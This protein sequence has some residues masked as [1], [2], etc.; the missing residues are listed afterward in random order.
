LNALPLKNLVVADFSRVLAG[1]LATMVLADLGADV[2]KVESP[3]T[4]DETRS[5]GPP[6][7][8]DGTSTYYLAVNRNK[9][10]IVLDLKSEADAS[11]ALR[12]AEMA[13]VVIENFRPGTMERFG[14]GYE[15]LAAVNPGV[16]F[17]SITGFGR[18]GGADLPGYDLL[19]QALGGLM[20]ITGA[21]DGPPTKVGVALVDVLAGLFAVSG[22]L[23]ALIERAASGEG[24]RVDVSLMSSIL[25]GLVNQASAHVVAGQTPGRIGNRHPS[26][27]PYETFT[28]MDGDLVI[29]VG[30]DQQFRRLVAALDL[31]ELA[32]DERFATNG[33]RVDNAQAL[34]QNIEPTLRMRA[35]AE[36]TA[37]LAASRIPCGPVNDIAEA[38]DLAERLGLDPV[39]RG[40][41]LTPQVANPIK[42]S[43]TP[44]T[45]RRSPPA[46]GADGDE[47]RA[48][49]TSLDS[50]EG[51]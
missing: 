19:A 15:D 7:S 27:S 44:P 49:L 20:S 5:W 33:A 18:Q 4:G 28:A 48:W 35:R 17:C 10:S 22:I 3:M 12:L 43:R 2:I 36:W 21:E 37:R 42:L 24:Q 51:A 39:C 47:V 45:Y 9:R 46:L 23:S 38:F 30:N 29:A 32:D 25:A 1:P 41:G 50:P 13:D 16:V 11:L 6:W 26:I 34:R 40:D 14:L 31:P 8:E